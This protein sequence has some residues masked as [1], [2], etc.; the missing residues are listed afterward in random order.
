M[1]VAMSSIHHV[2]RI[3]NC[4]NKGDSGRANLDEHDQED[5]EEDTQLK[6]ASCN[7]MLVFH[8][9]CMHA[10]IAHLIFIWN[11][12]ASTGM[13]GEKWMKAGI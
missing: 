7:L 12:M 3:G 1:T 8:S 13:V 2:D 9:A 5:L 6:S 10:I 11:V 4:C